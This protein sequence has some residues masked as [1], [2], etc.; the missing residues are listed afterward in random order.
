RTIRAVGEKSERISSIVQGIKEVADQTNLLALD[1]AIE[2]AR[3][4]EQGRGFAVV[5]DEAR[6]LAGR[7]AQATTDISDMVGGMQSSAEEAV[8]T[9]RQAVERVESGVQLASRAGESIG[10]ISDGTQ[11]VVEAVDEISSALKEQSAAS[12]DIAINI[13]KIA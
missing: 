2:A 6:K 1:A 8:A 11:R 10:G 3:A 12:N 7:T 5:A 4:G 9:M 13:E